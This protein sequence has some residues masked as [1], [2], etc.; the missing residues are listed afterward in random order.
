[1]RYELG[2]YITRNGKKEVNYSKFMSKMKYNIDEVKELLERNNLSYKLE[3]V[4]RVEKKGRGRPKKV[5]ECD[6]DIEDDKISEVEVE[7]EKL[8][9]N[10]NTYLKVCDSNTILDYKTYE[11]IGIYKNNSLEL[12]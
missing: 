7:V 8:V 3:E 4:K 10:N 6:S 12:Y 9:I 2:G 11:P 1:M 5:K